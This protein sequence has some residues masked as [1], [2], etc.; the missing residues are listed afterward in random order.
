M[1]ENILK[2]SSTLRV[3]DIIDIRK[4]GF[5]LTFK[6][7]TLIN[8]R[9]SATLAQ[10]CY[11]NITPE[12]ELNKFK[13]WFIGKAPAERREKGAGRPTKRERREIDDYK[14]EIFLDSW[15]DE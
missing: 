13:D 15:F 2:P 4:D 1:G 14:D 6:A 5:N 8:K 11:E 7:I 12:D 9:V 10:P 3:G